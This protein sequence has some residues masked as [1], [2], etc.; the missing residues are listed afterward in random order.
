MDTSL[1]CTG[2]LALRV[3]GQVV[4]A[5]VGEA[6]GGAG[7]RNRMGVWRPALSQEVLC[8]CA[9][10]ITCFRAQCSQLRPFVD[11]MI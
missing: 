7:R 9:P 3:D 11:W 6:G 2:H 8:E 1:P 4:A 10:G 5:A